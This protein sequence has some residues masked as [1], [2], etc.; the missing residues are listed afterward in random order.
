MII[1]SLLVGVQLSNT[2][3]LRMPAILPT[4]YFKRNVFVRHHLL[5]EKERVEGGND[6]RGDEG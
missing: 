1:F 4:T 5:F 2:L 6:R 3:S